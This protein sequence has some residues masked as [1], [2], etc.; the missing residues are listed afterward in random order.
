M[1]PDQPALVLTGGGARGAY[2]AGALRAIAKISDTRASP[3]RILSGV[4]AG[5]I[6][7]AYLASRTDDFRDAT[8]DLWQVWEGLHT[9]DVFVTDPASLF[10]IAVRLVAELS[11]GGLIRN[12]R[13]NYLLDASPLRNLVQPPICDPAAI[14]RNLRSGELRALAVTATDYASGQA[15]TF[16]DSDAPIEPWVRTSRIGMRARILPEHVLASSALP[17]FFPPAEVDGRF[18]ADGCIRLNAPLSTAVHLGADRILAI[19][20]RCSPPPA[21]IIRRTREPIQAAAERAGRSRAKKAPAAVRTPT[22][23]EIMGVLLNAVMLDGLETD[24]ERLERINRTLGLMTPEA[25]AVQ[26]LRTLP[27][28]VLRP[29]RD[30]GRLATDLLRRVAFP[31]RHMLR[32]LGAT[33]TVGWDLLSYLFFDRSYTTKLLRLGYDDTMAERARVERYLSCALAAR[34]A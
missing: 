9:A 15:I 1:L 7:A 24:I 4:S 26:P 29:S 8:R 2:Q 22:L 11:L 16:Y 33:E 23:A 6:N 27:L 13:A 32:G 5:A 10:R 30:L 17:I 14:A 21:E 3:F 34:R 28:T 25:R 31:L 18:Y 20:V 12:R 19:G